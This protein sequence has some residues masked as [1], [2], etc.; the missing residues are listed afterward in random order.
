MTTALTLAILLGLG[1]TGSQTQP[2]PT[3]L[4]QA[5]AVKAL[6]G[7]FGTLRQWQKDAYQSGLARNLTANRRA[8]VTC[9]GPFEPNRISGGP[10]AWLGNTRVTLNDAHCASNPEIPK[11]SIIWTD[12]GL[13]FVV[14]RGGA[15][16]LYNCE[17]GETADFD[18]WHRHDLGTMHQAPYVILRRGW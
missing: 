15:V 16:K 1:P 6:R 18:Y 4:F 7:D 17:R 2:L 13:R 5:C 8:K 9:Y 12:W 14:D 3:D 10:Y 11:G